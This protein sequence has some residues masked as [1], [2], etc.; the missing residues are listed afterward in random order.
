[1]AFGNVIDWSCDEVDL[2][3]GAKEVEEDDD[4]DGTFGLIIPGS[5]DLLY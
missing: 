1:M 4:D 2:G 3:S 5:S